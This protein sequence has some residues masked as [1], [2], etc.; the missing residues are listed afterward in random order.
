MLFPLL[1]P[2]GWIAEQG[3][4]NTVEKQFTVKIY[5]QYKICTQY[6]H[7]FLLDCSYVECVFYAV[8]MDSTNFARNILYLTAT[9]LLHRLAS[10]WAL[11]LHIRQ[12]ICW[13]ARSRKQS[14]QRKCFLATQI[15]QICGQSKEFFF[16]I[17]YYWLIFGYAVFL[18]HCMIYLNMWNALYC[19]SLCKSYTE[20]YA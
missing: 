9:V 17:S 20:T 10:A 2:K 11:L 5:T 6:R 14:R 7:D 8:L 4:V 19:F 15:C 12:V 1:W 13:H 18:T 16:L 3:Y